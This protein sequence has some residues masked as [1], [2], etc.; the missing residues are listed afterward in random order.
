MAKS[1]FAS[2]FSPK[3]HLNPIPQEPF[4]FI[5]FPNSHSPG[6]WFLVLFLNTLLPG[7]L[8]RVIGQDMNFT[9][10]QEVLGSNPGITTCNTFNHGAKPWKWVLQHI[11]C[12]RPPTYMDCK[13]LH[14]KI[15]RHGN[16]V[17]NLNIHFL[18]V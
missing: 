18:S 2:L 4:W 17:S 3:G 16:K 7:G 14:Q 15:L 12:A 9:Y 13:I 8:C 11:D 1:F 5:A 10:D 6:W